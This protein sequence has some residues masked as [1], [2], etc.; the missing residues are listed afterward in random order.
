M[1]PVRTGDVVCTPPAPL[2]LL[3]TLLVALQLAG[4]LGYALAEPA[5]A[6]AAHQEHLGTPD[7]AGCRPFHDD[8]FCGSCRALSHYPV[9]AGSFPP[10]A[11]LPAT[12]A[13]RPGEL[14]RGLPDDPDA[15]PLRARAPPRT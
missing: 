12:M 15:T 4:P 6:M 1:A 8:A 7:D 9:R 11:A 13:H 5:P 14:E 2:R 3:V 10:L